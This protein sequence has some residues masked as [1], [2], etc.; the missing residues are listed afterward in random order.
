MQDFLAAM[1]VEKG[2]S[3]HTITAY[4][5]ALEQFSAFC[6][7]VYEADPEISEISGSAS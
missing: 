1:D 4:R 3:Q 6:A 2:S 7:E 5:I